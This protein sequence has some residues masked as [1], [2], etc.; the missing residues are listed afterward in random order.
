MASTDTQIKG[1]IVR[2]KLK[3]QKELKKI[4]DSEK[5]KDADYNKKTKML[6]VATMSKGGR[7]KLRGGGMSQ[8]GLGKAFKKGGRA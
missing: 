7:A 4:T 8:R 5:Y 1:N 2:G 6:N 3:T